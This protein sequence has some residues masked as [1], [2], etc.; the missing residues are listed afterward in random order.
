MPRRRLLRRSVRCNTSSPVRLG[1]ENRAIINVPPSLNRASKQNFVFPRLVFKQS[2][3]K[4]AGRGIFAGQNIKKGQYVTEYLGE[5]ITAKVAKDRER[6]V[7]YDSCF[8]RRQGVSFLFVYSLMLFSRRFIGISK[9]S[10][11]PVLNSRWTPGSL[12]GSLINGTYNATA[13][14]GFSTPTSARKTATL[15]I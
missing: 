11:L 4:H 1:F 3:I 13:W 7:F 8:F 2:G 12:R 5:L 6:K 10:S 15:S 14:P 9:V